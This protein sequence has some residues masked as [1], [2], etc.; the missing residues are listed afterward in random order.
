MNYKIAKNAADSINETN[1]CGVKAVAI[2]T[3]TPYKDVHAI[4][5]SLGR[6]RRKGTPWGVL[7]GALEQLGYRGLSF[8]KA[9]MQKRTKTVRFG[10]G[11]GSVSF[12]QEK[13]S[14][15]TMKTIHKALPKRG[16]YILHCSGHVAAFVN[17]KVEDWT[18][19]RRHRVLRVMKI[20]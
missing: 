4:M 9:P 19:G 16:R 2:A 8:E 14:Y 1:D 5:A 17:G 12:L 11:A 7:S 20:S 6:K 18:E 10:T 13:E 15:Y 3:N